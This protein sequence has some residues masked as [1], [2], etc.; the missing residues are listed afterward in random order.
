[1]SMRNSFP[2]FFFIFYIFEANIK[3]KIREDEKFGSSLLPIFY[4]EA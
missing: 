1:M 4:F 2:P 3:K